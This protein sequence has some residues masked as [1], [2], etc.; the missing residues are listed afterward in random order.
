MSNKLNIALANLEQ[1]RT[2]ALE[3]AIADR[4]YRLCVI[5]DADGR[6]QRSIDHARRMIAPKEKTKKARAAA[7]EVRQ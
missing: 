2:T 4:A 1:A 7:K 5:L 3:A 6:I